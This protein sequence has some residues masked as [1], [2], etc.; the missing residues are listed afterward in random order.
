MRFAKYRVIAF[1]ILLGGCMFRGGAQQIQGQ[2]QTQDQTGNQSQAPIPAYGGPVESADGNGPQTLAP[3]K[4]PLT[5]AQEPSL[6]VPAENRTYFQPHVSV[7]GTGDSNPLDGSGSGWLAYTSIIGGLDL[8]VTSAQSDFSLTYLGGA[9]V[10]ND[11]TFGNSA[12]QQMGFAE[13]L[14]WRRTDLSFFDQL[15][16][17]PENSFGYGLQGGGLPAGG[18]LLGLQPGFLP[19]DSI[20]TLRGDRLTNSSIVELDQEISARTSLT[21]T[22]GYSL[23]H[24]SGAG[25]LDVDDAI[26]QAGYNHELS[27]TNTIGVLYIF[28]NYRFAGYGETIDDQSAQLSFGRKLTGRLA[29]RAAAGPELATFGGPGTIGGGTGPQQPGNK[30]YASGNVA[31][32]YQLQHTALGLNYNHGV[33]GGSGVLAGALTDQVSGYVTQVLAR[34]A[35][36]GFNFGYARN[37]AIGVLDPTDSGQIY[38]YWFGGVN[39]SHL[40]SR[41]A[42]LSLAYQVQYQEANAGF[43]IGVACGQSVIRHEVSMTFGWRARPLAF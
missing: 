43:C 33:S 16:F 39:W 29:L 17:I 8:H 28:N 10:S 37:R 4:T 24:Y 19:G 15:G 30:L 14:S 40:L 13:K 11:P 41:T 7:T 12:I 6:G 5:G 9:V 1:V 25:L 35:T 31:L 18:N 20:L 26:V 38:G 34:A 27:R 32:T 23:M 21:F 22:G 36:G 42:N 2:Q 3:D